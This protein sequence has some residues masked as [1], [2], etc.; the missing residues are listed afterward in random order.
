MATMSRALRWHVL[1]VLLLA[2]RLLS[3]DAPG[4]EPPRS[5]ADEP[6]SE[7][8]ELLRLSGIDD[9]EW[10]QLRNEPKWGEGQQETVQRILFRMAGLPADDLHREAKTSLD[11]K[12]L[13]TDPKSLEGD[14][15]RLRGQIRSIAVLRPSAEIARRFLVKQ[16][17]RVD[18]VVDEG[19]VPIVVFA[20]TVPRAWRR[21]GTIEQPGGAWGVFL[22]LRGDD[23]E[24]LTP[25]FAAARLASYADDRLLGT[26]GMDLGLFDDVIDRR[27]IRPEERECFYQLLNAVGQAKPGQLLE[28]ARSELRGQGKSQCSVEPLFNDPAR[29]RGK[30]VVLSGHIR[31]ALRV[32]VDDPDIRRRFDVDHYY[33]LYLYT[34]DSQGN[35]LVFCVRE[36]PEG[37]PTGEGP[38][39]SETV[40]VAGFFLKSWA[41]PS[42]LTVADETGQASEPPSLQL[43]PL[44]IGREPIWTG[45]EEV[46]SSPIW[47]AVGGGAFVLLLLG[48]WLWLWRRSRDD[49]CFERQ[50]MKRLRTPRRHHDAWDSPDG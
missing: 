24:H 23:P 17:Y 3:A 38:D 29:Q 12:Q 28:A 9:A 19:R 47:G 35:P 45:P 39:Y 16:Y 18:M 44:L 10:A 41:Y 6:V 1:I 49:R 31:R 4:A 11:S 32:R 30:L 37:M 43:A 14:V 36:L 42:E 13:M 34:D 8:R 27:P 26:L 22:T 25:L 46:T 21:G 15:F 48:V 20:R 2:A 50:T 33:E 40:T 5:L 7:V